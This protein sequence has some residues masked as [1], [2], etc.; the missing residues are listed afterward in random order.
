MGA[1]L[2]K[3]EHNVESLSKTSHAGMRL[4]D[5]ASSLFKPNYKSER[6]TS[7]VASDELL[8]DHTY[9]YGVGQ[10]AKAADHSGQTTGTD[11]QAPSSEATSVSDS[12]KVKL[13][14]RAAMTDGDYKSFA[15]DMQSLGQRA[16][17]IA[18]I[19]EKQGMPAE[20][21]NQK[22]QEQV[23]ETYRQV[24]TLLEANDNPSVPIDAAGRSRLAREIIKNAADPTEIRQG[25]HNTCNVATVE[26]RLYTR[27]PALA[28]KLV[29]DM[30]TTGSYVA[31]D[32]TK[33]A[34]DRQSLRPDEDAEQK[35]SLSNRNFASQIFQV[36]AVNLSYAKTQPSIHYEQHSVDPKLPGDGGERQVDYSSGK[37]HDRVPN[38]FE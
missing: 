23:N 5:E 15:Q 12:D 33:V 10:L 18:S 27:Q 29:V 34:L 20:Q 1:A 26:N 32:G 36:T 6:S 28:A 14:A 21:A 24:G 25:N 19:Y 2:E 30:A 16:D 3:H 8:L 22:A 38:W 37:P 17:K 35:N 13:S 11:K 7:G 4:S 9:I 31:K